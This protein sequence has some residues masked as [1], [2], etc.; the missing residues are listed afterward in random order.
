MLQI[1]CSFLECPVHL[2][3]FTV[4]D[5]WWLQVLRCRTV[6]CCPGCVCVRTVVFDAT[7]MVITPHPTAGG[8]T[9]CYDLYVRS[10]VYL[11]S[12]PEQQYILD[13]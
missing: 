9:K 13:M 5:L 8:I 3:T 11:M 4:F 10:V 7:Y 12:L 2:L 6:D 1:M